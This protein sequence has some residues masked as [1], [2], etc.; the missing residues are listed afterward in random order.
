MEG[1]GGANW[2]EY[3]SAVIPSEHNQEGGDLREKREGRDRKR[4]GGKGERRG[5]GETQLTL[6]G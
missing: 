6:D 4:G 3:G 5:Q 1:L 2:F